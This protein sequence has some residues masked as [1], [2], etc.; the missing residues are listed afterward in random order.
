MLSWSFRMRG[1]FVGCEW[2]TGIIVKRN[3]IC[4]TKLACLFGPSRVGVI[5][6][7][8][9][10][11]ESELHSCS[12]LHT[13]ESVWRLQAFPRKTA[14]TIVAQQSGGLPACKWRMCMHCTILNHLSIHLECVF[15][16][17]WGTKFLFPQRSLMSSKNTTGRRGSRHATRTGTGGWV[18]AG[19]VS[20]FQLR[21]K[22]VSAWTS[23]R[24]H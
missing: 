19:W 2:K 8:F 1:H 9:I 7:R 5:F 13:L 3:T 24:E 23:Y 12:L 6:H 20:G 15:G 14:R 16:R 22:M 10:Y 11:E 21:R 17:H 18:R 4:Q